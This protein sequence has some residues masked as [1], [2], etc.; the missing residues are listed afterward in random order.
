MKCKICEKECSS[1]KSLHA[2][3]SKNHNCSQS[4]YYHSYYPKYDMSGNG[5]LITYKNYQHYHQ[6]DFN[7][8]SS[9]SDWL[10]KNYS[11]PQVEEYC[12]SKVK[13]RMTKKMI[14]TLP[15]H[16]ELK[17]LFLPSCYGF[18]KI[19]GSTEK[20]EKAMKVHGINLRYDYSVEPRFQEGL[21]KVY[22]DTREQAPLYFDN[23]EKMKLAVGDY[24]PSENF[25]SDV[26]ID[27]KSLPDLAGTLAAGRARV[28]R[29]IQLAKSLGFY[30]IFVIED[31]YESIRNYSN[32]NS[33]SSKM[34]G[35]HIFHEIRDLM[36]QYDNIQFVTTGTRTAARRVIENIFR[37]KGQAKILDLE[38]LKDK[39]IL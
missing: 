3:L 12:V 27:R 28:E 33:F 13:E 6:S 16:F 26:Y 25:Y 14:T 15:S 9:F 18:E 5:E 21:M 29:E 17:S 31:S 4:D 24:S 20:F 2:H 35:D 23:S 22:I 30:L 1:L 19:Y 39:G 34:N 8:R 36:S 37:L 11:S 10:S 38:F 7:S 32:S